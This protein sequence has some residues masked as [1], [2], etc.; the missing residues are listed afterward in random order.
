MGGSVARRIIRS[1]L[2]IVRGTRQAPRHDARRPKDF[3]EVSRLLG[4]TGPAPIDGIG[5][6]RLHVRPLR[7]ILALIE[8]ARSKA[9]ASLGIVGAETVVPAGSYA[10]PPIDRVDLSDAD[11]TTRTVFSHY[12]SIRTILYSDVSLVRLAR[13]RLTGDG[14][15]ITRDGTV[16]EESVREAVVY[17]MPNHGLVAI[18]PGRVYRPPEAPVRHVPGRTLMIGRLFFQNFGHWLVEGLGQAALLRDRFGPDAIQVVVCEQPFS[19][20]RD[21]VHETLSACFSGSRFEILERPHTETWSFEELH[22]CTPVYEPPLIKVPQAVSAASD[23]MIEKVGLSP[24]SPKDARRIYISRRKV[25][26]RRLL[27]EQELEPL[28]AK[29]G[30][31]TV[32]PEDMPIGE[33]VRLFR[34]SSIVMGVKGAALT[35]VMFCHPGSRLIVLSPSDNPDPFFWNIATAKGMAYSELFGRVAQEEGVRGHRDFCVD[36]RKFNIFLES[37][38]NALQ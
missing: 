5:G 4:K 14:T 27:N 23:A 2:R 18:E 28:C 11:E 38:L 1:L 13:A 36:P 10:R 7:T 6:E 30:F 9:F 29:F 32:F 21:I 33:Q 20:M 3:G 17:G 15:V 37:Q 16:L 35:N 19:G 26:H 8:P 22:Y 31:E 25:R 12:M 24:D 34:S